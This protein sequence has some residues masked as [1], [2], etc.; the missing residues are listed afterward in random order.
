MATE[1]QPSIPSPFGRSFTPYTTI[2]LSVLVVKTM[3]DRKAPAPTCSRFCCLRGAAGQK[4]RASLLVC[5]VLDEQLNPSGQADSK[6]VDPAT[7]DAALSLLHSVAT[8]GAGQPPEAADLVAR[9]RSQYPQ[10]KLIACELPSADHNGMV[11]CAIAVN[12]ELCECQGLRQAMR[13][14]LLA[15]LTEACLLR[16]IEDLST[17]LW[18]A[19]LKVE[20]ANDAAA[21]AG[22]PARSS[23]ASAPQNRDRELWADIDEVLVEVT[24]LDNATEREAA[25]SQPVGAPGNWQAVVELVVEASCGGQVDDSLRPAAAAGSTQ[26][27]RQYGQP[28]IGASADLGGHAEQAK[29]RVRALLPVAAAALCCGSPTVPGLV[30]QLLALQISLRLLESATGPLSP[31]RVRAWLNGSQA[32]GRQMSEAHLRFLTR[33]LAKPPRKTT[34]HFYVG[35]AGGLGE[36]CAE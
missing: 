26:L 24:G 31:E 22:S 15:S 23:A 7:L 4:L 25:E 13:L 2:A 28:G 19:C 6:H 36:A 29:A 27:A 35:S 12:Q 9:A 14:A 5:L 8:P 20:E 10:L 16:I 1:Q 33:L 17:E 32:A 18:M 11:D 21:P 3:C 30:A 34:G